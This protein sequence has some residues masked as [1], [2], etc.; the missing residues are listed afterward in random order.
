MAQFSESMRNAVLSAILNRVKLIA[1][2]TPL[3][4]NALH[5]L[6]QSAGPQLTQG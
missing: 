4:P 2:A 6:R 3:L 5:Q 1:R